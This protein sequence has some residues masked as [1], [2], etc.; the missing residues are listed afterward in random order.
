MRIFFRPST[1]ENTPLGIITVI[2]TDLTKV[3]SGVN[4]AGKF[5]VV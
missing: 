5:F 4:L 1:A 3:A 2:I